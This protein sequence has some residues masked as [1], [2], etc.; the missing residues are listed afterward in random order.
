MQ[1]IAIIAS[2]KDPAGANI[3]DNLV[4]LYDFKKSDGKFDGNDIFQ[5]RIQNK[6]MKL[7]LTNNDLI[8]SED[9]DKKIDA[10]VF[11]FA[12]KHR[13]KENTPSFAVHAIGNWDKNEFG[14]KEKTLCASSAVLLKNLFIELNNVAKENI[15][16][17]LT[18]EATH[19]GPFV[20]KPSV[21]CEIGST[22]NEWSDKNNGQIMAKTIMNAL[23]ISGQNYESCIA[24]GGGHYNQASNKLMLRTKYAV[25]HICPK[26]ALECLDEELLMQA[27]N[28]TIPKPQIVLVDWKGLG[29]HKQKTV[30]LLDS[31]KLRY[32]RAQNIFK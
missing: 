30:A 20:G 32:E 23:E 25:G 6:I 18:L 14:G 1:Q 19:H 9:L 13:S 31:L 16:Y 26:Y 7:Y 10:D 4:D 28:N 11:I 21:F 22:E 12:S 8:F 5:Y 15:N 2:S 24:L 3:R 17:E 27:I 29:Q